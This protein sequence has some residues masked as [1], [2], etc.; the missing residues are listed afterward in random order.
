MD[1]VVANLLQ[2]DNE[3]FSERPQFTNE[4][5]GEGLIFTGSTFTMDIKSDPDDVSPLVSATLDL[6][7]IAEG[8][9]GIEVAMGALDVGE[10][11]YDLVRTNG[12]V[13]SVIMTGEYVVEKGV[14][15]L[16]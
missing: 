16:V 14:T 11:V 7:D 12:T 4:E 5:T 15:L 10:Y 6:T 3:T 1:I 8:Y 9:I 13:R 2:Y